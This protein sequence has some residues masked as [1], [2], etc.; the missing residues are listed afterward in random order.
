MGTKCR[1][2]DCHWCLGAPSGDGQ[3]RYMCQFRD[4]PLSVPTVWRP[5]C[6]DFVPVLDKRAE[7][8]AA[9]N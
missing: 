6:K 2:L 8:T 3:T 5:A 1:C 4:R 9:W 7:T